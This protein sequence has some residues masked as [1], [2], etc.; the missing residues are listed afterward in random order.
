MKRF[1]SA[2]I[3]LLVL[4]ACSDKP[5]TEQ[6]SKADID[7]FKSY[8]V[9][10]EI[11]AEP[12]QDFIE[13]V[14]I[15]GLEE[16]DEALLSFVTDAFSMENH[17]VLKSGYKGDI[18]IYSK[19]GVFERKINR[20]GNGPDE[21]AVIGNMWAE[22]DTVVV[23]DSNRMRVVKYDF[24]GNFI[25]GEKINH[26]G[27]H[28]M[29]YKDGYVLDMSLAL[30]EDSLKYNLLFVDSDLYKISVANPY[31]NPRP[32]GM[33]WLATSFSE[34]DEKVLF[35][36]IYGDT[37]YSLI[38][39][40]AVPLFSIDFGDNWLWGQGDTYTNPAEE[41]KLMTTSMVKMFF[42][43]VSQQHILF[44]TISRNGTFLLDRESGAYHRFDLKNKGKGSFMMNAIGWNGA[45]MLFSTSSTDIAEFLE[46]IP[47]ENVKFAE[48]NNLEE[49]ESSENP[50]LMWVK[51]KVVTK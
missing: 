14:E 13:E 42:T 21:Y 2:L 5:K 44:T 41:R 12:I 46:G 34:Y 7:D 16:T 43:E 9:D 17:F 45:K 24:D 11:E 48:G 31:E 18:F 22:G 40:K 36:H 35:H 10:I 50:V 38:D 28:A 37:I 47:A 30:V 23:F 26:L 33:I 15:I 39:Y 8:K 49:I 29:P 4:N 32:S 3:A 1:I 20:T 19:N 51:F 25:S 6:L 27:L